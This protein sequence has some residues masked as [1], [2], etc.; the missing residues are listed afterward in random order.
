MG[1]AEKLSYLDDVPARRKKRP[2]RLIIVVVAV[3]VAVVPGVLLTRP[4]GA[5]K[6][7]PEAIG[8]CLEVRAENVARDGDGAPLAKVLVATPDS[9]E[10]EVL[11]PPP[12]PHPGD[13]IP[14]LADRH[15]KGPA[16]YRADLERW[17]SEGA[18]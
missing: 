5:P 8:M 11:L 12:V 3:V 4:H 2:R 14:L 9:T 1:D 10:V 6:G 16:D 18:Q 15:R 13:F 7:S 17:K